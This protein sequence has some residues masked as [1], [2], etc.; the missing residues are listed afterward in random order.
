M[1]FSMLLLAVIG[2]GGCALLAAA[3][4]AVIWVLA[5]ERR[6]GRGA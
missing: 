6:S 5:S 1:G 2:I 4:I 3:L